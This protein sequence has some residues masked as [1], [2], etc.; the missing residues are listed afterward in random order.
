MAWRTFRGRRLKHD[1]Q[2]SSEAAEADLH[3]RVRDGEAAAQAEEE[4]EEVTLA[5][6]CGCGCGELVEK[7][8]AIRGRAP[9]HHRASERARVERRGANLSFAAHQTARHRA[10]RMRV[11]RR[12]RWTCRHCGKHLSGR[13]ATVDYLV[14]VLDGGQVHESNAVASCRSCNARAGRRRPVS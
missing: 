13:D 4:G 1:E 7:S 5:I 10:V 11:L 2:P 9:A 14:S 3:L 12:D 8:S 6:V